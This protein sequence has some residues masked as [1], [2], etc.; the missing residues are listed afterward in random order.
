M[1]TYIHKPEG[2]L[3]QIDNPLVW[4]SSGS[5]WSSKSLLPPP[6]FKGSRQQLL[7][8]L[9]L[10][11]PTFVL[12]SNGAEH[13]PI[14]YQLKEREREKEKRRRKKKRSGRRTRKRRRRR[15]RL[16]A[17][18]LVHL[19]SLEQCI[20]PTWELLNRNR[21][22]RSWLLWASQCCRCCRC[23]YSIPLA[24]WRLCRVSPQRWIGGRRK[25]KKA[26]DKSI[27]Q[28]RQWMCLIRFAGFACSTRTVY[29][30]KSKRKGKEAK[31]TIFGRTHCPA[32]KR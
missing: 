22:L 8:L 20:L 9:L 23:F 25:P 10:I 19:A 31:M 29:P 6:P 12:E 16:R 7:H 27:S 5:S 13:K 2:H 28:S 24:H 30:H 14:T 15:R 32:R 3:E 26:N 1:P 4:P 18:S 21:T 17:W 11:L